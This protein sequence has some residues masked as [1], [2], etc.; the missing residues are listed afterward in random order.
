[1]PGYSNTYNGVFGKAG[2]DTD[3]LIVR[4][5]WNQAVCLQILTMQPWFRSASAGF[6][7]CFINV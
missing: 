4:Q 6:L 2:F 1:M 5:N 3:T 7:F